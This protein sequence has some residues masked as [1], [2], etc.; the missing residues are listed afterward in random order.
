MHTRSHGVTRMDPTE[1][2]FIPHSQGVAGNERGGIRMG[3]R[4]QGG[5]GIPRVTGVLTCCL[6][7]LEHGGREPGDVKCRFHLKREGL[8][9]DHLQQ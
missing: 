4:F 1:V 9:G 6:V 2:S 5:D 7:R 8:A 3:S